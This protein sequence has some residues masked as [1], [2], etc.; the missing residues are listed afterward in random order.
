MIYNI[1]YSSNSK[2][3]RL[4]NTFVMKRRFCYFQIA[5]ILR[6]KEKCTVITRARVGCD[7]IVSRRTGVLRK[8]LAGIKLS[9]LPE[10]KFCRS[11]PKINPL[12]LCLKKNPLI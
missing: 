9:V 11:F 8:Y 2:I 10:D 5:S 7:Y 6:F 4:K 3:E 12:S 1:I